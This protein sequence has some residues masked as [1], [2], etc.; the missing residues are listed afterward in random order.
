MVESASRAWHIVDIDSRMLLT[1]SW[2]Y[3]V[4]R[5]DLDDSLL[6]YTSQS[7]SDHAHFVMLPLYRVPHKHTVIVSDEVGD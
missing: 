4:L 5:V 7:F 2:L 6:M 3:V 1:F